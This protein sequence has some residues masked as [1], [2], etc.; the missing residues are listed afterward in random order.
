MSL[1]VKKK[2]LEL[3]RVRLGREELEFKILEKEDEV[4]R[5]K[6]ALEKQAARETE[7]ANEIGE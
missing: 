4:K 3:S 1:E 5:L 7:L 6:E 2:K